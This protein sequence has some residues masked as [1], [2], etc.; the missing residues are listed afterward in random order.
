MEV[1]R[2]NV[3]EWLQDVEPDSIDIAFLD[4]PFDSS[5]AV[6]ALQAIAQQGCIS[7]GGFVYVEMPARL[8]ELVMQAPFELH[9]EKVV[10]EVRMRLFRRT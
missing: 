2:E 10:G 3:L 6:R 1:H 7:P 9:R 4:P 8:P 5:L